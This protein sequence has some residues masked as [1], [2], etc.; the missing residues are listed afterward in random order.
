MD[1]F[2]VMSKEQMDKVRAVRVSNITVAQGYK[3]KSCG[4]IRPYNMPK[5]NCSNNVI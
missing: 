2:I 5:C 4:A 1:N 3:C